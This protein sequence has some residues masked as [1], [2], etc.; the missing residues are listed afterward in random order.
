MKLRDIGYIL[1]CI[2]MVIGLIMINPSFRQVIHEVNV[3]LL[4]QAEEQGLLTVEMPLGAT[5][6]VENGCEVNGVVAGEITFSLNGVNWTYRCAPVNAADEEVPD[7]SE[8]NGNF[9]TLET[10]VQH[11]PAMVSV[12]DGGAGK[13]VWYDSVPGVAYSLSMAKNASG[14]TLQSI[15]NLM[16][17]PLQGNS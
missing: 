2:F 15:A 17:T 5:K 4:A 10:Q 8:L 13:I 3:E 6:V 7:I 12:E 14:D 9:K 11:C 16:Y 1:G